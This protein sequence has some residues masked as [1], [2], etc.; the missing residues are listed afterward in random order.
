MDISRF[1]TMSMGAAGDRV[2]WVQRKLRMAEGTPGSFDRT[3]D[4]SVR[5]FQSDRGLVADG[6]IGPVTFAALCWQPY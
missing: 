5:R 3:M 4:D 1:F 2:R 6:V